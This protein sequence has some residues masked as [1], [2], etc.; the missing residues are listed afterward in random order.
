[1]RDNFILS[2]L[3]GA[4]SRIAVRR[5][6][7]KCVLVAKRYFVIAHVKN[8]GSK[9]QPYRIRLPVKLADGRRSIKKGKICSYLNYNIVSLGK[10]A[11][12]TEPF[13]Y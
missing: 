1:M 10:M 3:K 6:S 7:S 12:K 5:C 2:K 8:K 4:D 9:K 11:G 13:S